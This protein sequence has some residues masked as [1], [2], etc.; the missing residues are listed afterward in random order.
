[1]ALAIEI[2]FKCFFLWKKTLSRKC[3]INQMP[4][5]LFVFS[6]FYFH[7]SSL[8]ECLFSSSR[9]FVMISFS[10]SPPFTKTTFTSDRVWFLASELTVYSSSEKLHCMYLLT[11]TPTKLLLDLN[12][13]CSKIQTEN[14]IHIS[15]NN[16]VGKRLGNTNIELVVIYCNTFGQNK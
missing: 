3:K 14:N 5:F 16:K 7:N 10:T 1:M 2:I 15:H 9:W 8:L 12:Q 13:N 11:P 4:F 6:L